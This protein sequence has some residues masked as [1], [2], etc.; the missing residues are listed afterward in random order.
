VKG[1]DVWISVCTMHF[2]LQN[3][4]RIGMEKIEDKRMKDMI[5]LS[6]VSIIMSLT[7]PF[8]ICLTVVQVQ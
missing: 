4:L 3:Q 1:S 7:L 6:S 5:K 8:A 2:H